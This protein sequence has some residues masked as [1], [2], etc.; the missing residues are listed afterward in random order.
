MCSWLFSLVL[1][2]IDFLGTVA[3][4]VQRHAENA[5]EHSEIPDPLRGPFPDADYPRNVWILRQS[6][7]CL[8]IGY[9]GEHVDTAG[10]VDARRIIDAGF[11]DAVVFAKLLGASLRQV[12]HVV[13]GSKMQA[14]GR[15]GL[16]ACRFQS[17]AHPV[18]TKRALEHLLG[19]GIEFGNIEW[20][21][22]DAISAANAI[23]LLKIHDAVRIL[24]DRAI[25]GASRQAAPISTVHALIFA[26]QQCDA[27]VFA[28]VLVELD[29]VPVIPCRLRHGLVAVVEH[30]LGERVAVPFEAR[31]FTGLAADACRGVDQL[32]YQ[33]GALRVLA[34]SGSSVSR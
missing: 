19:G 12:L 3:Q 29:Q 7:V 26:H 15:A 9:I 22:A 10:S 31:D 1:L 24:H 21:A 27:A 6:A 13:F 16:N 34:G 32:A 17:L 33:F 23:L 18:H 5:A 11:F 28:L 20:T 2:G 4:I 8:G 30:R 14:A 25:R